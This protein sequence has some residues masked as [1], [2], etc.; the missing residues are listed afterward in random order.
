MNVH[1]WLDAPLAVIGLLAMSPWMWMAFR[2]RRSV[3]STSPSRVRQAARLLLFFLGLGSFMMAGLDVGFAAWEDASRPRSGPFDFDQFSLE[4][5]SHEEAPDFCLPAL[6]EGRSIRLSDFRGHK[7]VV[8][9][10][11]NFG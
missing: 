5:A 3:C 7:P 2:R 11:G 8:L 9:I 4:N 6:D 1:V 10:F